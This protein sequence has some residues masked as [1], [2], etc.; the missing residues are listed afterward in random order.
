MRILLIQNMLYVPIRGGANKANKILMEG[1]AERNHSCR[2]VV[3]ATGG[4]GPGTHAEFLDELVS[5]K[6]NF[7]VSPDITVFQCN[8]VEVHAVTENTRLHTH[9]ARQLREFDPTVILVSSQDPGNLLLES[10]LGEGNHRVVY[11]VHSPLDLPFGLGHAN[12]SPHKAKLIRQ[13][14]GII[15]VSKDLQKRIRKGCGRESA[16]IPFPVYGSGPF[17]C[18]GSFDKGF[19][20]LI[21]PCAYKGI[22]IFEML[23]RRLPEIQLAAVP[24]WGTTKPDQAL[25]EQFPNVRLIESADDINEVFAQTRLLL[26]PS[27][28]PEGYPLMVGGGMLRGIPVLASNS[29]GLPEAKLGVDYVLPV[30][31][32]E[33]YKEHC[34]DMNLPIPLVPEQNIDPWVSA[35]KR[36]VSDPTHYAELS[37][38]SRQAALK[39]VSDL[40]IAPFENFLNNIK[41]TPKVDST[42]N[43]VQTKV[44]KLRKDDLLTRIDNLSPERRALL[45]LKLLKKDKQTRKKQTIPP[46]LRSKE[47]NS[48]PLS[49]APKRLWLVVIFGKPSVL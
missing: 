12:N 33:R 34:D 48:F 24:T 32:I 47:S 43:R 28:C 19:V 4:H 16:V 25:L 40:G 20:T 39:F 44:Q 18:L 29:G 38:A 14:D 42:S 9:A 45:A 30:R 26:V 31:P 7:S 21:N 36:L 46:L 3:P 35:L 13:T 5:R 1:L 8:R 23:A 10:V 11:I 41:R 27:L 49:F 6:I 15:T 22:S 2:V 17:P 37:T